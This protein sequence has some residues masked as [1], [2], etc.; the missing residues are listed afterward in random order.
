MHGP[1]EDK[2]TIAK[3]IVDDALAHGNRHGAVNGEAADSLL[4]NAQLELPLAELDLSQWDHK[5]LPEREWAVHNR[6]P[7]QQVA[8]L[9]G[10]GAA[11]KSLIALQ[12]CA[13]IA[14]SRP[15]WLGALIK[16]GHAMFVSAEDNEGELIRRLGSILKSYGAKFADLQGRLHIYDLSGEDATLATFH[17]GILKETPL[18]RRLEKAAFEI[19]PQLLVLDA[20]ADVFG[21]DEIQRVQVRKF[22]ARLRWGAIKTGGSVLLL[23]HPSLTGMASG[24]G[25][26]GSTAWNN[27]CRARMYFTGVK[28]TEEGEEDDGLRLLQVV[29]SNYGPSN[30]RV[31]LRYKAGVFVLEQSNT[32]EQI[33]AQC[34]VDEIF[35]RCLSLCQEQGRNTSP[36][37]TSNNYA[38]TLFAK[39]PEA[40]GSKKDGFAA[41]MERLLSAGRIRIETYGPPSKRQQ[42]LERVS[43]DI[44]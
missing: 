41:S 31:R 44:P 38:P 40:N 17:H 25:L 35:L 24:S 16:P 32:F 30:E 1:I 8:M 15:D 2:N 39:M 33:A 9:S 23:A 19:C 29:K 42:R 36:S 6:I 43:K 37:S 11:G 22:I 4:L 18:L 26:S 5:A 12:L 20:S 34:K 14:L 3:K 10:D 13:S 7:S 27:S 28:S 21:G